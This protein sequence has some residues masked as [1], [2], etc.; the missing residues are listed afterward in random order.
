MERIRTGVIGAGRMGQHH[1]RVV[2]NQ[3]DAELV[4]IYDVDAQV[5]KETSANYAVPQYQQLDDLLEQVDA[6]IVATPTPTHFDITMQCLERNIHVLVEKPVTEKVEDAEYLASYVQRNGTLLQVGHI[7]RFNPTY[8]ELKKVLDNMSLIAVNFRRLS[9]YRVSNKDVDVVV[10]L[11]VHDLDL[12]NDLTG[13]EPVAINAYGLMPFSESPDHVVAQLVYNN[14]P[15][16]TLTASRVTEQKIRS[17]DVTT[18]DAFVEADF[19]NKS[20]FIHRGATGEYTGKCRNGVSYRQESIIEC[21]LVPNSEPLAL[22]I[23]YFLECIIQHRQPRVSIWDGLRALRLAQD[24]SKLV[25][26]QNYRFSRQPQLRHHEVELMHGYS[27][28]SD[29]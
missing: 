4:G 24:I 21:I 1:C 12:S 10:D 9:P 11:M 28:P 18:E 8:V 25:N 27:H 19:M 15:L 7:E 6:V 22:E 2:A 5:A 14:G 20:I 29:R 17:V 26:E 16:I 23:K 3:K 13:R